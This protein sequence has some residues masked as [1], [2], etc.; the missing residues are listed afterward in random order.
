MRNVITHMALLGSGEI[1]TANEIPYY[2]TQESED[3]AIPASYEELKNLKKTVKNEAVAKIETSFLRN[4]LTAYNWNISK[5]AEATG[6][7]RR[8]LQNM[9]KKYGITKP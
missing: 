1:I 7:D 6:I 2:M 5:T 8:L 3:F 9:M 4:S